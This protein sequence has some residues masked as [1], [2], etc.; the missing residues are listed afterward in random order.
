MKIL[1]AEDEAIP[2]RLLQ[3]MLDKLGY[4][5]VVVCNGKEAWETLQGC[6]APRFL[7]TFPL[8]RELRDVKLCQ[9]A[10]IGFRTVPVQRN[11]SERQAL[12]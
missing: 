5:V 1:I 4:E 2:R 3:S 7:G 10:G 11:A 6:D 9:S 12:K 8:N